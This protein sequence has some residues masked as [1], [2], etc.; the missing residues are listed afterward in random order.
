[1]TETK[2]VRVNAAIHAR[3]KAAGVCLSTIASKALL[4]AAITLERTSKKGEE[5][6][7]AIHQ[8]EV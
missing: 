6:D 3:A 1:M 7:G 5:T 4:E 2:P 8:K